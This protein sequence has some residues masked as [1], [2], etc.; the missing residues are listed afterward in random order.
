MKPLTVRFT[1]CCRA[2]GIQESTC[3][4]LPVNGPMLNPSP[5]PGWSTI[6]GFYLCDAHQVMLRVTM[7]D[8]PAL[9]IPV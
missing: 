5:P 3:H 7:R 9:E 4:A 2:C 8:G 1:Y 6:A